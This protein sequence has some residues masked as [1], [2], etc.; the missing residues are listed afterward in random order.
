M[1][2]EAPIRRVITRI[3]KPHGYDVDVAADGAEAIALV[4]RSAQEGWRYHLAILDLTVP[5]G[6]G[7]VEARRAIHAIEPR[8]LA[9]AS[10]GYAD[11]PV[12]ADPVRFGF[13]GL[14]AKP[15]TPRHFITVVRQALEHRGDDARSP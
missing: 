5:G 11:A 14:I 7:G 13:W 10:S 3:L 2:D 9:I 15:Y 1:D 6:M 12:M 8:T 4:R